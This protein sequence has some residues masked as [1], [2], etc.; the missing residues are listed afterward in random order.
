MGRPHGHGKKSRHALAGLGRELTS[1]HPLGPRERPRD[2]RPSTP[3]PPGPSLPRPSCPAEDTG[4]AGDAGTA[5]GSSGSSGRRRRA[6]RGR[7]DSSSGQVA[8]SL[9][10]V[11]LG[12]PASSSARRGL[13][14]L[15][16]RLV[17]LLGSWLPGCGLVAPSGLGSSATGG[18]TRRP[19][20]TLPPRKSLGFTIKLPL[21]TRPAPVAPGGRRHCTFSSRDPRCTDE[22]CRLRAC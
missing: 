4:T 5:E 9:R 3:S 13:T 2:V 6:G 12:L 21:D 7:R 8:L 14:V 18:T 17:W 1:S 16:A 19:P 22:L 20:R 15:L 11:R 10:S